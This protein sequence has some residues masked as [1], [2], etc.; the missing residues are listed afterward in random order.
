M[1]SSGSSPI[2]RQCPSSWS[3]AATT[4]SC[5]RTTPA[6][7]SGSG[8]RPSPRG[9]LRPMAGAAAGGSCEDNHVELGPV[10]RITADALGEPGMRTFYLQ[11]RAGDELVT[12]VVEK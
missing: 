6:G 1:T 5:W 3:T 9:R 12:V 2:R 8:K 11:A 7:S 4:G 10:D